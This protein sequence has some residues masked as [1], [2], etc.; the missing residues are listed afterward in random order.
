MDYLTKEPVIGATVLIQ[1]SQIGG[2]T[3]IDGVYQITANVQPG[4]YNIICQFVSFENDTQHIEVTDAKP[5]V[6]DFNIKEKTIQLQAANVSAKKLENTQNA[7]MFLKKNDARVV[8]AISKE[9]ISKRADGSISSAAKRITGVN[10]EAGKYIYVR[11]L[12]DRYSK[13]LVNGSEIPGLDP[14]R[15]TVQLDFFPSTFIENIRIDKS[16]SA[17]LPGDFSG[18]IMT[19]ATKKASDSLTVELSQLVA[20]NTL[21]S[22]NKN[23]LTYTSTFQDHLAFDGGSRDV[24]LTVKNSEVPVFFAN[25][26]QLEKVT[27][28]FSKQMDFHTKTSPLN[29]ST[30]FSI[31]N[32]LRVFGKPLGYF[33]GIKYQKKFTHLA[34]DAF[35]GRYTLTG[36]VNEVD[37]LTVNRLLDNN[38]SNEQSFWAAYASLEYMLNANHDITLY[39]LRHQNADKTVQFSEGPLP[40]DAP[41]I[42]YQTSALLYT[43]RMLEYV[44]V[45]GNSREMLNHKDLSLAYTIAYARSRQYQPDLRFFNNDY[46]V[47]GA[48]TVYKVQSAL[49]NVP[50]RFYR[51]LK[52]KTLNPN[53]SITYALPK[54][55]RLSLGASYL[56]KQRSVRQQRF[57]YQLQGLD[58]N[59]QV[60]DFFSDQNMHLPLASQTNPQNGYMYIA[61][62]SE[63]R[64]T[65]N[66]SLSKWA[67]Y[68]CLDQTIKEKIRVNAGIRALKTHMQLV[69]ND[70][71]LA[72][73]KLDNFNI[74]PSL[75]LTYKVK[76]NQNLRF[77][78]SHAIAQ[79]TFREIAP[80]AD[81]DFAT[82]WVRIG[83][84]S[85]EQTKIQNV[86]LRYELYSKDKELF[87]LG[88]FYKRFHKPIEV[89]FN[90]LAANATPEITWVN[91]GSLDDRQSPY[92][93]L[94]GIECEVRKKVNINQKTSLLGVNVAYMHSATEIDSLSMV[95]MRSSNPTAKNTRTLYGQSPYILNV[96][97]EQELKGNLRSMCSFNLTGRRLAVVMLGGI[98]DVYTREIPSLDWVL[99]KT[100]KKLQIRCYIKNI[101]DPTI[102]MT[103]SYKGEEYV[104]NSFKRGRDIGVQLGYRF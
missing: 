67:S 25:N 18:G 54:K 65:Y 80:F 1:N 43:Q 5:L 83:N 20:Y 52:E 60:A 93:H 53:L 89:V 26:E 88:G 79:P 19:I 37:G 58:F 87:S 92:A 34:K 85:L 16:F 101:L 4:Q 55:G 81:Y 27:Q 38:K 82:G 77:V 75:N 17:N 40:S 71:S 33:V 103:H 22:L 74:L 36:N 39:A 90:P 86:D 2:V 95:V 48:D 35:I 46:Q 100:F 96:F 72:K 104:F 15:N 102:K 8:E 10:V 31:S 73:A 78:Y 21:S 99:S 91:T 3:N 62:V 30:R 14:D 41:N 12:S 7:M 59:G 45:Q 32:Q 61:D 44:S 56:N 23:F 51:D 68:L 29:F 47:V 69:S 76:E 6:V 49:Y 98:P 42:I 9:E 11:G 13:T 66:G 84:A 70:V 28:S 57:N 50:T 64:N 24:P 94:Y 97:Y 63:L